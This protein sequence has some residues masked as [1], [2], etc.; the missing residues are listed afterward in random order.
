MTEGQLEPGPARRRV[1]LRGRL[2]VGSL[3]L[4]LVTGGAGGIY[5]A[6]R[7]TGPSNPA[8][9]RAVERYDTALARGDGAAACAALAPAA[10][11]AIERA[12]RVYGPLSCTRIIDLASARL[13]AKARHSI[14]SATLRVVSTTATAARVQVSFGGHLKNAEVWVFLVKGRWLVGPP[15][16]A[17]S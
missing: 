9:A 7:S 5:Q 10:Q 13:D 3:T 12:A 8:P 14:A 1:R 15:T 6:S 17:F 11:A 2:I 4:L 16:G